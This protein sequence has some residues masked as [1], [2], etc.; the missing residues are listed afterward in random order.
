MLKGLWRTL[1][2]AALGVVMTGTALWTS[3]AA[4]NAPMRPPTDTI[5]GGLVS[6]MLT[7]VVLLAL[8]V[9][10]EGRPDPTSPA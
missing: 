3:L 1:S 7:L 10:F 8:Y 9:V 5:I 2:V 4:Q 6:A